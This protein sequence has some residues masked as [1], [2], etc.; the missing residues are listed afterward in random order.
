[1]RTLNW[2]T[3]CCIT[4][5]DIAPPVPPPHLRWLQSRF[6]CHT[7]DNSTVDLMYVNTKDHIHLLPLPS[8]G[9]SD[10][11]LVHMSPAYIPIVNCWDSHISLNH[12]SIVCPLDQLLYASMTPCLLNSVHLSISVIHMSDLCICYSV[13]AWHCHAPAGPPH[14][15]WTG[16]L[17]VKM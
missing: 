9:C 1:M 13:C 16:T 15:P 12:Q 11:S 8:L 7:R 4:A 2:D 6:P 10:H 5:S 17:L 3:G 14:C